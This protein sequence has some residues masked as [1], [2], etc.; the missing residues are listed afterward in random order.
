MPVILLGTL[1]G[2]EK[3][4]VSSCLSVVVTLR[5][6]I[7]VTRSVTTTLRLSRVRSQ[8]TGVKRQAACV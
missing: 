7:L 4:L 8:E 3:F 5:V 6:R 1:D 2:A